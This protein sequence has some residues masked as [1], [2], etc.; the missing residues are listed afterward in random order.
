MNKWMLIMIFSLVGQSAKAGFE[1]TS[2]NPTQAAALVMDSNSISGAMLTSVENTAGDL[3]VA[4]Q[5]GIQVA[6]MTGATGTLV[7]NDPATGLPSNPPGY[8][9]G[10]GVGISVTNTGNALT[11]NDIDLSGGTVGNLLSV[12][13]QAS[14]TASGYFGIYAQEGQANTVWTDT[15]FSTQTFTNV[16]DG[17]GQVLIGEVFVSPSSGTVTATP[18]PSSLT[19]LGIGSVMTGIW[20]W[21]RKRL[22]TKGVSCDSDSL[23]FLAGVVPPQNA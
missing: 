10:N 21:R 12:D 20:G 17:T 15:N 3:L 2:S 14:S 19:L 7:F 9:F 8:I 11:A 13:F 18:E 4:W 1:L 23:T 5:F 6:Q 16:P 22:N